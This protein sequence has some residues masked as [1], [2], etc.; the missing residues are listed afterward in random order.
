MFSWWIQS[1]LTLNSKSALS[2]RQSEVLEC[3]GTDRTKFWAHR[4]K[5]RQPGMQ[6]ETQWRSI[7]SQGIELSLSSNSKNLSST[8]QSDV[9]ECIGAER[10]RFCKDEARQ[11]LEQCFRLNSKSTR[12]RAFSSEML[13][14]P[15]SLLW[16]KRVDR[17]KAKRR[18]ATLEMIKCLFGYI[19]TAS[20]D[21]ADWTIENMFQSVFDESSCKWLLIPYQSEKSFD[22]RQ[23]NQ[24][25][26][27]DLEVNA[28]KLGILEFEEVSVWYQTIFTDPW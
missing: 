27:C 28:A 4:R 9:L 21:C 3:I 15:I 11:S 24:L 16:R 1:R 13:P 7:F 17:D 12:L 18:F 14:E 25:R 2:T 8:R 26:A 20:W 23:R 10:T 5:I 19:K 22:G 6:I